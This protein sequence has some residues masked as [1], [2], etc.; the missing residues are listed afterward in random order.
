MLIITPSA[1]RHLDELAVY[2]ASVASKTT[3]LHDACEQ[4]LVDQT[5]LV[6]Y[7][8][9]IQARLAYFDEVDRL[10]SKLNSPTVSVLNEHFVPLLR[11]SV[12]TL[13]Q[14]FLSQHT[15]TPCS[16]IAELRVH[17]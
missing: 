17:P 10:A 16:P 11:Y 2:Y 3:S 12:L 13:P 5:S 7:A 14:A 1:L 15:S 8:D 4:L 9:S 6:F